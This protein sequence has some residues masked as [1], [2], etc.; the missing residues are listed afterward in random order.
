MRL[1]AVTVDAFGTLLELVDPAK[2]L[3]RALAA[4][5]YERDEA[6][7][8]RAFALEAEVYV[9]RSHE[10]R[11]EET[12]AELRR[13]CAAVFLEALAVA[14]E[15]GSFVPAFVAALDF[16]LLPGT[17]PALDRLRSAS[18]RLA[19]VTN[20]DYTF[21]EHLALLGIASRFETVVTSAEAGAPKPD[22]AI[23]RLALAR[24]GVEPRQ[25]LHVGD[26]EADRLG[27]HAAG[28]AFAPVPLATLP[29][30]L[31][32]GEMT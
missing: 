1:D 23:F 27:A 25:A 28:L 32:L 29:E 7:V 2:R 22:P 3:R 9:A 30:R 11:D 18:F 14:L 8:A 26:S 19:C 21:P 4:H 6:A 20:W 31:G 13:D 10:G 24:L 17:V 15:P 16:R 12:L 5:G